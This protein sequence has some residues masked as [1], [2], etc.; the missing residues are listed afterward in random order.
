MTKKEMFLI[1][2]FEDAGKISIKI[3]GLCVLIGSIGY[4]SNNFVFSIGIYGSV[5]GLLIAFICSAIVIVIEILSRM[6]SRRS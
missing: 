4:V 2:F 5:V 1:K 6:K 3:F